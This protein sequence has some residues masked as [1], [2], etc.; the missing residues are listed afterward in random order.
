MLIVVCSKAGH[1]H[2]STR[3]A[4]E[5]EELKPA[6]VELMQDDLLL[7]SQCYGNKEWG[8]GISA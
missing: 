8:T 7:C 5:C 6:R 1:E 4:Q 3:T 2:Q